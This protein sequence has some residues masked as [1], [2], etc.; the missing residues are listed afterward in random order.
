MEL[1]G[2]PLHKRH[3][4]PGG[5]YGPTIRLHGGGRESLYPPTNAIVG[6]GPT[7]LWAC[8]RPLG[9]WEEET[10]GPSPYPQLRSCR[11][12]GYKLINQLARIREGASAPTI[13]C[14]KVP[15]W[16]HGAVGGKL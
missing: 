7:I 14:G 10:K 4:L 15:G 1:Q 13:L 11:A 8:R 6:V 3:L 12:M 5:G 16:A 9:G 2:G